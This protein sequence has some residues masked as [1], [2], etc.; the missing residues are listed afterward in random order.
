V[1]WKLT[2]GCYLYKARHAVACNLD[3]WKGKG[4]GTCFLCPWHNDWRKGVSQYAYRAYAVVCSI[5]GERRAQGLPSGTIAWEAH[6]VKGLP[7][8]DMYVLGPELLIEVD[9]EGHS[10]KPMHGRSVA[11]QQAV[12]ARKDAGARA[13]GVLLVR[14]SPSNEGEWRSMLSQAVESAWASR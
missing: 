8:F 9:G 6:A 12:D 5:L 2:C 3:R 7:A 11:S 14:L 10:S 13:A 4:H 1:L